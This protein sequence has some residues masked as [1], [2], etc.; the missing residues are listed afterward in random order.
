VSPA[1][2]TT[3]PGRLALTPDVAMRV[4]ESAAAAASV[5]A[6]A[7]LGILERLDR[8]PADAAELEQACAVSR[9][10]AE[11][12]LSALA[13]LGLLEP[14][15]AGRYAAVVPLASVWTLV[16]P[17][18]RLESAL[19]DGRPVAAGDTPAGAESLY[20]ELVPL[21][22]DLF[23]PAA[24]R[25]ARLLA[26]TGPRMLDVGAG[27]APWSIALA[28]L[29]PA[30]C[31]TAIDLP[32]VLAATRRAVAEAGLK[33]QFELV[34]GDMFALEWPH[35]GGYDL[36]LA[37][38]IC[39]LFGEDPNHRLLTRLFEA[40]RPGGTLAIVDVLPGER[41]DGPRSTVLYALGLLL[42]SGSGRAYPLSTYRRWLEGTGFDAIETWALSAVPPFT[43]VTARR[44]HEG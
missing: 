40:A 9:R 44:P 20:A 7:R 28:A 23:A 11:L 34:P 12:L 32:E 15:G 2:T 39:H 29:D 26:R 24:H 10:G 4:A 41:L 33:R 37:A 30:R 38:N 3:G 6:A 22:A 31:V 13:G 42:R 25:A 14:V 18:Q 16:E 17:W 21:L 19:V 36:V 27:A 5:A 43:L 1:A 8:R 35:G